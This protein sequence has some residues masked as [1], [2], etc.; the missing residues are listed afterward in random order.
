MQNGEETDFGA[1]VFRVS[2][3]SQQ[4]FGGGSKQDIVNRLFVIEGDFR[5]LF[6][7]RKYYV[8]VFDR[9]QFGLPRFEPLRPLRV[10]TFRTM[11]IAA[12]VICVAGK[13]AAVAFFDMATESRRT[14]D[15]DG[16][17]DAQLLMGKLVSLPVSSAI[18][19]KKIGH[20]ERGPW[21]RRVISGISASAARVVA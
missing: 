21:H 11:A 7:Q 20:F 3:D 1:Q 13:V 12:G 19:S 17:H 8:K 14:A 18:P 15:F 6:R 10:L 16:A 4:S 9:Q 5:N 2:A